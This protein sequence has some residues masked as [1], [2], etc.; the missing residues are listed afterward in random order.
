MKMNPHA[1]SL[2]LSLSIRFSAEWKY[3]SMLN[4]IL[5]QCLLILSGSKDVCEETGKLKIEVL[6]VRWRTMAHTVFLL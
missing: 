2:S 6:W 4:P 3:L 1:L 5:T